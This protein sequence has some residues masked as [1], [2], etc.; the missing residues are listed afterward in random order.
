ML[1][2]IFLSGHPVYRFL[3]DIPETLEDVEKI[4]PHASMEDSA[5]SKSY[6]LPDFSKISSFEEIDE[7]YLVALR[8][9]SEDFGELKKETTSFTRKINARVDD[10]RK[11]L[12]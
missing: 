11:Y 6:N 8:Y 10:A 7:K 12:S 2:G 4:T 1:N 9:L 3:F 5:R